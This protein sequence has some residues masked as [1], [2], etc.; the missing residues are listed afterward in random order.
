MGVVIRQVDPP[1]RSL[2]LTHFADGATPHLTGGVGGFTEVPRPQQAA[3]TRWD[4]SPLLQ[5]EATPVLRATS[6]GADVT[7]ALSQLRAWGINSR[8]GVRPPVLQVTGLGYDRTR[9]VL[10]D[11]D[12]QIT[13]A[14]Y[15][16][17]WRPRLLAVRVQL[18]EYQGLT[19]V[20]TAADSVRDQL[21]SSR[22]ASRVVVAAKGQTLR[23]VSARYLGD[24]NRWAEIARL[25]PRM[26]DPNARFTA[27][28]HLTIPAR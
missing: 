1:G 9:W 6:R 28:H 2:T 22:T 10:R 26:R 14:A 5:W 13:T 8:R 21:L 17:D 4:G 23:S 27:A 7:G 18:M 24:G 11:L 15:T 16:R 25:N 20:A 3:G 19:V 12:E